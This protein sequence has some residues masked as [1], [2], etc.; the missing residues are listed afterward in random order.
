MFS[1][2]RAAADYRYL[3]YL[4]RPSRHVAAAVCGR[5]VGFINN[6]WTSSVAWKAYT[7]P[8]SLLRSANKRQHSLIRKSANTAAGKIT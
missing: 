5:R 2:P 7:V 4:I 1:T 6:G 8:A 3:Y